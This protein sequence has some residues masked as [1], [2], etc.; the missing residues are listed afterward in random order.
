MI[1]VACGGTDRVQRWIFPSPNE[2]G[3]T[4]HRL[5]LLLVATLP[6]LTP[7]LEELA[8]PEGLPPQV[9]SLFDRELAP[10]ATKDW[11]IGDRVAGKVEAAAA[12][13]V[14]AGEEMDEVSVPIGTGIAISCTVARER[15]DP[16]A[17]VAGVLG[18]VSKNVTLV[19]VRPV[20]LAVVGGSPLFFVD[21]L[22]V[23]EAKAG[24][25][26]GMLKMAVHAHDS[27]MFLCIHDEGG[28]RK[29]FRRIARG[30]A[31]AMR[32]GED[33]REGARYAEVAGMRIGTMPVG[34]AETVHWDRKG[35]GTIAR[36]TTTMILPR[37]ATDLATIDSFQQEAADTQDLLLEG[38]Y[39]ES[40]NG[41][42][43]EKFELSQV[44]GK[45]DGKRFKVEGT[46]S[47]KAVKATFTA[48]EGLASD[49]WFARR[50]AAKAKPLAEAKHDGYSTSN[51]PTRA[52]PMTAKRVKGADRRIE[53]TSGELTYAADVDEHG[54]AVKAELPLGPVRMVVERVWARGTP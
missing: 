47:G 9:R 3:M 44:D 36:T 32:G 49:L 1:A 12:P 24:K 45:Q 22:Y 39:L 53:M 10:L 42:L 7:A 40:A 52:T 50:F 33:E 46:K 4:R 17:W 35:G 28:Y 51:D 38:I 34:F 16:G 8:L 20:D 2:N 29:S 5:L 48:K 15:M 19:A 21:A 13:T 18:A 43:S 6:S 26:L 23:H 41:E 37:T 14:A 30:F 11:K 54:Q 31:E 27:H 25:Q